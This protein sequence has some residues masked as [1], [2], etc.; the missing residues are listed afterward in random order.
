MANQSFTLFSKLPRELQDQIWDGAVQA[1][2]SRLIPAY[3]VM[4]YEIRSTLSRLPIPALLH[5][6]Q[7]ARR[8][9][10]KRWELSKLWERGPFPEFCKEPLVWV[11]FERDI[12]DDP[13]LSSPG[14]FY[15]RHDEKYNSSI[16]SFV[17]R[18]GVLC[19]RG[20]RLFS[21]LEDVTENDRGFLNSLYS[22]IQVRQMVRLLMFLPL[23]LDTL[24]FLEGG[25]GE[26]T[27]GSLSG[28]RSVG[29][30]DISSG[31]HSE[32]QK[33]WNARFFKDIRDRAALMEPPVRVPELR[34]VTL[35]VHENGRY[36]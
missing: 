24:Y 5:T 21:L 34:F 20:P 23:S 1:G 9:A 25:T 4:K 10:C 27:L 19:D 11:D 36:C 7:E 3:S 18:L 16:K 8:A 13:R 26:P 30:G 6:C 29:I 17:I 22:F 14:F 31:E 2:P 28:N 32:H 33:Q 12:V 35:Q 15:W